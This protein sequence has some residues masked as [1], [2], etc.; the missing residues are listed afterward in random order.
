MPITLEALSKEDFEVWVKQ[1]EEDFA[2]AGAS[3][4]VAAR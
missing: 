4:D 3:H 2:K 1:A